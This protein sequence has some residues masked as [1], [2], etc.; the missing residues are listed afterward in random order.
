MTELFVS[1]IICT[2]N[3]DKYLDQCLKSIRTQNYQNYEIIVVNG[4]STDE[5]ENIIKK[6]DAIIVIR[7]EFLYGISASRNCGISAARGDIVAFIDDDAVA[8]PDWLKNLV[9]CYH[10]DSV[11]SVGGIVYE[12]GKTSVQFRNGIINKSGI[13]FAVRSPDS[14]PKKNQFPTCIGTNCSFKKS[15]LHLAGGFDPYFRYHLDESDLCVRIVQAGFL[16]LFQE[17][18]IVIH[19]S[20]E[21]HNRISADNLNSYEIY[22]NVI[23]FILKNFRKEFRSY[24]F[25]PLNAL[26]WWNL[27]FLGSWS[28]HKKISFVQLMMIY[29]RGIQGAMQGYKDGFLKTE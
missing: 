20:A 27:Y 4:P 25:R 23:Y 3:R 2:Y 18:A 8:D 9:T 17:G 12:H 19:R 22:K 14:P 5:T 7:Q 29:F 24:T 28:I 21:G 26:C 6:Y 1:V 10:D 16:I 15:V 13:S 11:G